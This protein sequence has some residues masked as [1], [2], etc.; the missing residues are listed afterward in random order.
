MP[1]EVNIRLAYLSTKVKLGGDAL[2]RVRKQQIKP[3]RIRQVRIKAPWGFL[4][5]SLLLLPDPSSC[6]RGYESCDFPGTQFG[7]HQSLV[8]NHSPRASWPS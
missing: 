3:I 2:P 1:E 5:V 8:I 4:D 6:K 7:F